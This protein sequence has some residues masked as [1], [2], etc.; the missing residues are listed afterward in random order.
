MKLRL[1]LA[2]LSLVS[3]VHAAEPALAAGAKLLKDVSYLA[4]ERKEKLDV[5]LPA[6]TADG[7]FSPAVVWI[8]GGGWTGG[9]KEAIF[10]SSSTTSRR[11][12]EGRISSEA[13]RVSSVGRGLSPTCRA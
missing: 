3:A 2:M 8:H 4:P 10:A 6:P 13:G 1:P 12:R 7:K 11:M 5:Y 9:T